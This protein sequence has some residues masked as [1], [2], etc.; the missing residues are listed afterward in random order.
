M[1]RKIAIFFVALFVI[2]IFTIFP[3]HAAVAFVRGTHWECPSSSTTCTSPTFN[4]SNGDSI[5]VVCTIDQVF[6]SATISSVSDTG[7]STYTNKV[8]NTGQTTIREEMWASNA[9]SS[10]ASSSITVT[11]STSTNSNAH[12]CSAGE[13]SGS[14]SY[15]STKQTNGNSGEALLGTN[16]M[17]PSNNDWLVTGVGVHL[18][19]AV[20][21]QL[22]TTRE[23]DQTFWTNILCDNIYTGSQVLCDYTFASSNWEVDGIIL[24]A[25][26][27]LDY[28]LSNNGPIS[29]SAGATK[30]VTITATSISSPVAVTLSC[31]GGTIPAGFTCNSF[32]NNPGTPTFS[33]VLSF[34]VAI[35]VTPGSYSFN[36]TGT[37]L[38]ATT[39]ATKV[40][41]TVLA[42]DYSLSNNSPITITSG[43]FASVVITATNIS[44]PKSI[45]LSCVGLPSGFTCQSFNP[46][47]GTP[48]F[49][50]TLAVA[51]AG[52]VSPGI[53]HFNVTGTALGAT[54]VPTIVTVN[55]IPPASC[56]GF[57]P[58]SFLFE[59][60]LLFT[61]IF[62][63][64]FAVASF[65]MRFGVFFLFF[66]MIIMIMEL[67]FV[68]AP[69]YYVVQCSGVL[70]T[71]TLFLPLLING[72]IGTFFTIGIYWVI[73]NIMQYFGRNPFGRKRVVKQP[74]A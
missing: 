21:L 54:T 50:S 2:G 25:T 23:L 43:S 68:G 40:S 14:T 35:S 63:V 39:K 15:G 59:V 55:V 19:S 24:S 17:S 36:V 38:G 60:I 70:T 47:T 67:V 65:P 33:S 72:W 32:T 45:T 22:G 48:T 4:T 30:Q 42:F 37:P 11:L 27:P 12:N 6:S 5:I 62:L 41:V 28:S 58:V 16:G 3:A 56:S 74:E 8:I 49:T 1:K 9:G 29:I 20:T 69:Q 31:V 51:T 66:A 53:Y 46:L 73:V 26:P 61:A 10:I 64:R 44:S 13:Y 52:F 7:G 57:F 71:Q 34:T 18:S